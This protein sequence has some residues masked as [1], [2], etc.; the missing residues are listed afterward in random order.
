M[1]LTRDAENANTREGSVKFQLMFR[2]IVLVSVGTWRLG[3]GKSTRK[4][5]DGT[6]C[7]REGR[8][9]PNWNG[10]LFREQ[11]ERW[12]GGSVEPNWDVNPDEWKEKPFGTGLGVLSHGSQEEIYTVVA[13]RVVYPSQPAHSGGYTS[14]LPACELLLTESQSPEHPTGYFRELQVV[15]SPNSQVSLSSYH[16]ASMFALFL[17]SQTF[18]PLPPIPSLCKDH[19]SL[20]LAPPWPAV[21]PPLIEH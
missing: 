19:H 11:C 8:P 13:P 9:Q 18:H 3:C 10:A 16:V 2:H 6:E 7:C 5:A 1:C 4:C 12:L 20:L 21:F 17:F 14:L 15:F